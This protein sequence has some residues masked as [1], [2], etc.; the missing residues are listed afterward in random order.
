MK[1]MIDGVWH[2]DVV[3]AAGEASPIELGRFLG[4][5]TADGSSGF[6]AEAGRYHLYASY[7]CP[8]AHR[9]ILG[10][11]LKRLQHAVGLSILHPRWNTPEGW[12]FGHMPYSTADEGGAGFTHL[13]QAYAAS[14]PHYTGKVTVPVLWDRRTRQIVS[15]E[16][17]DILMM[18]NEA[19]DGGGVPTPDLY[20]TPLRREIDRLNARIARDLAGRVYAIGGARDQAQYDDAIATL[21]AFLDALEM[22]LADGRRFL[23]GAAL[24][25]SDILAF[26]PLV[27]FDAIYNP[28]FR[29][30]RKRLVDY[31]RLAAYVG[32]VYGLPGVGDTVR[33]DHILMHYHDGDWGVANR[34]GIVPAIPDV[35]FRSVTTPDSVAA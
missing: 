29:A 30:S 1:L 2:A 11:V 25:I 5:V 34:R 16:S 9:V 20:P 28:L 33:F 19:F 4:R 22:R 21:F 8:F 23:H 27:R 31:P 26:T 35:D 7:A 17:L 14:R 13:H 3:A 24:T 32:R 12:V 18:F 6:A 15:N 10:R